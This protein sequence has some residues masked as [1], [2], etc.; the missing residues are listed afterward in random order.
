MKP[1]LYI[2]VVLLAMSC[3]SN[4]DSNEE[5]FLNESIENLGVLSNDYK[6][7]VILP[8]VGCHGCIQDGEFFMKNNINRKD[9]LFV[10]TKI[11]SFKILQQKIGVKLK[12][13]QNVYVD[14]EKVFD[15]PS[16]NSIYPCVVKMEKG[17]MIDYAFQKPQSNAFRLLK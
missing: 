6:W 16:E 5:K 12:E 13:Y 1:I 10:L 7:I 4:P 2:I 17:K 15:I 11:S 3:K 8:G 9:I 14:R